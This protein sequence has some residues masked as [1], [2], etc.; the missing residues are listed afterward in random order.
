MP[1][2]QSLMDLARRPDRPA[3]REAVTHFEGPLLILAGAGSGKT[4]VITRRVAY[5]LQQGVRPGNI[6]AIT[7]TNK[8]AGEMRQRVEALVPGS[9]VWI[10]TFHSLGAR[11]L[12][13]YADRLGLDRNFTIYDQSD[14][15]RLVKIALEDA[16]I[17]NVRFTP[18]THPGAPS[19]RPRT[20]CSAPSATPSSAND[21]F[22]QTVAQRLPRLRE[23]AARRQRPGLRRPALLAR[24]GPE[25]RRRA[26]RRTRR[27]LP[28]R[29]HRRVPGHQP[30]PVRHRPRPVGRSPEP[31]RGR[32]TPTSRFTDGA[33]RTSA[34]S[35]ISS[36]TSPTPACITLDRNYRS[37]KAILRAAS[38]LI[39]H[40]KQ[41]KP[42]DLITDNPH[43]QPVTR[44]DLRDR[45]GRGRGHRPAHPRGRR[46]RSKRSYRDFAVFLRINALSR[47]AGDGVR[48]AAGAVPDRQG[49]GLLR[50]QGEPRRAGLPAAA[51]QPA[52]RPVVPARRQRAGPRHRQGVAGAPARVRR[53]ARDEPAGGRRR[54]EARPGD[55][56]QGGRG[57]ARLRRADARAAQPCWTRRPT[58]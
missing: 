25:E 31:V 4:R 46:G 10:S 53:A 54:G 8:A 45:P 55:Q 17:D 32:A 11:L 43:G 35:S 28:L 41:R 36:A 34:I 20:S 2:G 57:A 51:A 29:P 39:A 18:E 5:L 27:P 7:F 22:S 3:Q 58:R 24:P 9:R 13:Q 37:T 30:R 21:F 23:A 33:A 15:S 6:L 47:G 38:H 44:A 1:P 12:R 40:N 19:A 49:P 42:K 14:R 56:G 48:Q 16:G 26:A 50:P 52:R